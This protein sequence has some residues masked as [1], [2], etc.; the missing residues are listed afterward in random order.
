MGSFAVR[1][2]V[3]CGHVLTSSKSKH[4]RTLVKYGFYWTIDLMKV[5]PKKPKLLMFHINFMFKYDGED[6]SKKGKFHLNLT[7]QTNRYAIWIFIYD[8]VLLGKF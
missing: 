1:E 8:Q 2:L 4:I 3:I 7:V 6:I 5:I